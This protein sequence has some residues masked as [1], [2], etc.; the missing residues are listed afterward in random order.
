MLTQLMTSHGEIQNYHDNWVS[1]TRSHLNIL[2]MI[3]LSK[4]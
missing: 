2:I 1:A 4:A 3:C